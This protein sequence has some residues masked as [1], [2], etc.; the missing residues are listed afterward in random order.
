L[1]RLK[2]PNI[3][4]LY[5]ASAKVPMLVY[6]FGDGGSVEWQL[7]KG[8]RP[9]LRDAL[10]LGVQ[11][12]D[13]LRYIHSRG[14]VHGDVKP[15]N[16]FFVGGI[17]KVGDFSTLTRLVARTSTHSRFGYTPGFRAP[18]QAY[19]DLRRKAIELG[20]ES[21][22]DVYMLGN[23][24]LHVLT[25]ESVDGEDAVRPGVVDDAVKGV[26]DPGLRALLRRALDPEPAKRPSSEEMVIE[27][28]KLLKGA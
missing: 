9:S 25:G 8:W 10:L 16:V 7:S 15:G 28:L 22:M 11:V 1:S 23:L 20:L 12:G 2:H 21:R 24:I 17:A 19:S 6:E 14:L 26:E 4:R 27:L 18:E 5:G 3:L 13:A